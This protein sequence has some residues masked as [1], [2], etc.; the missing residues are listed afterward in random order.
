MGRVTHDVACIDLLHANFAYTAAALYLRNYNT[1]K[2]KK[3][4]GLL[5]EGVMWNREFIIL[6]L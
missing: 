5:L 6:F 1:Q 3:D 4:F 2:H